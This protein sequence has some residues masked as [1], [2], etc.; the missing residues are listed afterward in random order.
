MHFHIVGSGS[1]SLVIRP[2]VKNVLSEEV[3]STAKDV[4]DKDTVGK[5]FK[6]ENKCEYDR[7]LDILHKVLLIDNY[8]D[9]TVHVISASK[10][11]S[12]EFTYDP[13]IMKKVT[14]KELYQIVFEYGGINISNLNVTSISFPT[15]MSMIQSFY[16]GIS[17]MQS[18]GIVHR[19]IKPLNVLYDGTKLNIIDFGLACDVAKLY[20]GTDEDQ[21]HILS[22]MY[23]F[24]PPEFYI[25]YLVSENM[26][27]GKDF[28]ESA[29][30]A[31]DSMTNFTKELEAYYFEHYYRYNKNEPYN[32][33]SYQQAFTKFYDMICARGIKRFEDLFNEELAYKSDIYSTSFVLKSLKRYI[34][35]ENNIQK[36]IFNQ[37][38]LMTSALNPLQR[39]NVTQILHFIEDNQFY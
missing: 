28:K 3:L 33:F 34:I 11:S 25:A 17:S 36:D 4:K 26:N 27:N 18:V 21:M 5:L 2:A 37:L 32:I 31:F 8:T 16:K 14:D 38:F 22:Y 7:E 9:F 29:D 20:D 13:D 19:D 30:I 10:I 35:F 23:M 15:F 1:N 6:L 39:S 24:N 12:N